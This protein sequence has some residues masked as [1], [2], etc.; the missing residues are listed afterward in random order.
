MNFIRVHLFTNNCISLLFEESL[1]LNLSWNEPPGV[2]HSFKHTN[3]LVIEISM[4]SHYLSK[5]TELHELEAT[6]FT[7]EQRIRGLTRIQL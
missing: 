7:V 5:Q 6:K 1:S 3:D 2:A 4:K